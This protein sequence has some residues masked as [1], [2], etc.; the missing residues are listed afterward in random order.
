MRFVDP[1]SEIEKPIVKKAQEDV[2]DLVDYFPIEDLPSR[3]CFYPKETMLYGRRMNVAEVKKIAQLNKDNFEFIINTIL[4]NTIKGI[5]VRDIKQGDKLYLVLWLRANTFRDNSFKVKFLCPNCLDILDKKIKENKDYVPTEK[6]MEQSEFHFDLSQ[7]EV[8]YLPETFNRKFKCSNYDIEIVYESVSNKQYRDSIKKDNPDF[9]DEILDTAS[10]IG[11]IDGKEYML[12]EKYNILSNKID[13][14]SYMKLEEYIKQN[15]F[16]FKENMQVSCNK[17]G[18]VVPVGITFCR[19]F[20][21][22]QFRLS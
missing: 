13:P 19:E 6:E 14:E 16:G 18:G 7:L 1:E 10:N 2:G 17:C 11:K 15:M 8:K 4:T 5:D 12:T 22:P 9:D 3:Y 20:M 21:L